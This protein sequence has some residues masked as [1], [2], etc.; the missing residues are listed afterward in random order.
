MRPGNMIAATILAIAVGGLATRAVVVL[1]ED[2]PTTRATTL[3]EA[4]IEVT[5]FAFPETVTVSIGGALTWVNRD[6]AAHTVTFGE[7]PSPTP[8]ERRLE[9]GG[10]ATFAFDQLGT[11]R[12]VCQIHPS[13]IGRVEVVTSTATT[14]RPNTGGY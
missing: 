14:H 3:G 7:S 11:Y 2:R 1:S 6:N 4:A 9:S 12:Y 8:A 5:G 13:M 10:S